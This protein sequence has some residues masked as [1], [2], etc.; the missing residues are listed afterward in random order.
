MT[1]SGS[2][3]NFFFR[4]PCSVFLLYRR[5][6]QF[7]FF[8]HLLFSIRICTVP[9]LFDQSAFLERMCTPSF[10]S[11][12]RPLRHRFASFF[13]VLNKYLSS[14]V[15]ITIIDP[16]SSSVVRPFFFYSVSVLSFSFIFMMP[17]YRCLCRCSF[18]VHYLFL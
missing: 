4:S 5:R 10:S 8:R 9:T 13:F 12:S 18:T 1:Q 17:R 16:S 15:K 3:R 11:S 6:F 14:Q 7:S 2:V